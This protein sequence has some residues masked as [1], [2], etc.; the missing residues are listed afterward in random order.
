MSYPHILTEVQKGFSLYIPDPLKV[1]EHYEQ[2]CLNDSKTPFPFW[3]KI[4]P[5][6]KAIT[7]F[8]KENIHLVDSRITLEIGAGIG[9]PSFSIAN[10][11]S[12]LIITDHSADAIKLIRKNIDY[13]QLNNAEAMQLDWNN[14][15]E[16]LIA[17]T[18]I[19]SDINYDPTQIEPLLKLIQHFISKESTIIISTPE[20]ITAT[21]FAFSIQ[22]LI[23]HSILQTVKDSEELYEIRIMVL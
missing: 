1:K 20:R 23:K 8:L 9:L 4:W 7:A 21:S 16:D 12:K 18:V 2:M 5:S 17:D 14:F 3:A 11:V 22:P 15:P 6:S 10:K 19:L 13:L